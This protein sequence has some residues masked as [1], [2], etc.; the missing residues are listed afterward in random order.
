MSVAKATDKDCN[1]WHLAVPVPNNKRPG[2]LSAAWKKLLTDFKT[3][4]VRVVFAN[5]RGKWLILRNF[6]HVFGLFTASAA[7]GVFCLEVAVDID[8]NVTQVSFASLSLSE[9]NLRCSCWFL[10]KRSP[11]LC[12]QSAITEAKFKAALGLKIVSNS[13]SFQWQMLGTWGGVYLG[14]SSYCGENT[15]DQTSRFQFA[16]HPDQIPWSCGYSQTKNPTM[17][18]SWIEVTA[19]GEHWCD[20]FL[21]ILA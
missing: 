3:I 16:G 17:H 5:N 21:L 20:F 1:Q 12:N 15:H 9:Q 8:G 14:H 2:K 4:Y 19:F 13:D 10:C 7:L 18:V 11:N 6:S